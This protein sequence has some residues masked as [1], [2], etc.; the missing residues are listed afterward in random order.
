MK[1]DSGKKWRDGDKG[2]MVEDDVKMSKD[3]GVMMG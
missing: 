3:N 2:E 1:E